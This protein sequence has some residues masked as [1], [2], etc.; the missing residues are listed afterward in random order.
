MA[1]TTPTTRV[2]GTLITASIWNTDMVDD[3]IY[4]HDNL[5]ACRVYNSAN[6]SI[7][8]TTLTAVTFNSERFDT[9][10]IHSTVS[11][12]SRLTCQ[13]AGVYYIFGN[14][15]WASAP[16]ANSFMCILLNAGT[17]IAAQGTVNN[18]V[19]N[20]TE[21]S[22]LYKLAVSDYVEFV[23]FQS[24]G[25]A[26]NLLAAANYSPEFGMARVAAG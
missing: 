2:T 20:Q 26:I 3:L 17:T 6:Q 14:G 8:N 13:T 9:D 18:S 19:Q 22:C 10:S 7:N 15:V 25:G 23:V 1:W 4:L 16:G 24:S 5:P 11:S 12:T 21:V